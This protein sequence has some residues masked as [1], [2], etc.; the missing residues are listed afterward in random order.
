MSPVSYQ[1]GEELSTP[2]APFNL[3]A[4]VSDRIFKIKL[5]LSQP[6]LAHFF[7]PPALR[8]QVKG[9]VG[10]FTEAKEYHAVQRMAPHG[11]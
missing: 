8:D 6:G 9:L 1:A 2:E 4:G 3:P 5:P 11:H 7:S 10:Y